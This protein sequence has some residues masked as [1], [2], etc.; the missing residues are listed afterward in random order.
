MQSLSG[1]KLLKVYFLL[2]EIQCGLVDTWTVFLEA[3]TSVFFL[4]LQPPRQVKGQQ[5][6]LY[7]PFQGSHESSIYHYH[8]L[9]SG[10]IARPINCKEG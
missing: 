6:K 10:L 2:T 3:T 9:S 8:P 5:W 4:H 1:S 7:G